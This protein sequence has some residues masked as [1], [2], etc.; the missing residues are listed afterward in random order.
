MKNKSWTKEAIISEAKKYNETKEFRL[1]S[2][3]QAAKRMNQKCPGF[4]NQLLSRMKS[5]Q[6]K[7]SLVEIA[8]EAKKH[9]TIA[10]F[11]QANYSMYVVYRR[12]CRQGLSVNIFEHTLSKSQAISEKTLYWTEEKVLAQTKKHTSIKELRVKNPQVFAALYHLAKKNP[13]ILDKTNFKRIKKK[14]YWNFE[15]CNEVAQQCK[16]RN[17]FKIK[18]RSAYDS[19]W[20]LGFLDKIC[21]HMDECAVLREKMAAEVLY[22]ELI[23]NKDLVIRRE[24]KIPQRD[25]EPGR[26]DFFIQVPA[27]NLCFAVE[28]KHDDSQWNQFDLKHQVNKY[29]RAFRERKGFCGTYLVSPGGKY[30]FSQSEFLFILENLKHSE[31]ILLPNSLDFVRKLAA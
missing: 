22:K 9:R 13:A 25:N 26:V 2:A 6:K 21:S 19:A 18:C 30:G 15:K 1:S 7:Y 17:E 11:R 8:T 31:E 3:Y 5:S 24:V 27:F 4:L 23:K 16:T 28:F 14:N 10:S 20:R 29:N 12:W